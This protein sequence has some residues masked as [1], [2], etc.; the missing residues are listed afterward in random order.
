MKG[1][2]LLDVGSGC[3]ILTFPLAR[4]GAQVDGLEPSINC[5]QATD[6]IKNRLLTDACRERVNFMA[7]SVEDHCTKHP[8]A[9]DAIVVSEVVEHVADVHLFIQSCY[10]LAK[11]GALL[12]FSTINRTLLSKVLA[13]ELAEVRFLTSILIFS[14]SYW[15]SYRKALT[16]GTNSSR[17]TNLTACFA[18]IDFRL[19]TNEV[20]CMIL[21]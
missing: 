3:G 1:F 5:V 2:K 17:L 6:S 10:E 15:D 11:P 12:F 9:Y 14:F 16:T 13:V 18:I 19:H 20:L 4:L 21:S 8:E 7:S